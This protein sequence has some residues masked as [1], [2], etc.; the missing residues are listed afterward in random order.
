[1]NRRLLIL[2][3]VL[4]AGG[5]LGLILLLTAPRAFFAMLNLLGIVFL[6]LGALTMIVTLRKAKAVKPLALAISAGMGLLTAI[7]VSTF[8]PVSPSAFSGFFAFLLGGL[9]GSGWAMTSELLL[10]NGRICSRGNAWYLLVWALMLALNQSVTLL[11]GRPPS[12]GLMLV[13]CSAGLLLGQSAVTFLRYRKLA[14]QTTTP[15]HT[16]L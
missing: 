15:Q 12:V 3:A 6:V 13:W 11:M 9:I 14:L 16:T 10:E 8:T 1:M 2:A 5:L 4:A 7:V